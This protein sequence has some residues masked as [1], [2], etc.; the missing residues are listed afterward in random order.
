MDVK[1]LCLGLLNKGEACGYDLKKE[2]GSIFKHF[3]PAGY[4]SIY[5]AL[6]DLADKGLVSCE[7]IPQR[8]KPDRKT[9]RI[10]DEGR[11]HFSNALRNTTPRH[12]MRSEFLAMLYFSDLMD[13]DRLDDLLDERLKDLRAAII[14]IDEIERGWDT[15][16]AAGARFVAG[17]GASV[18][19]AAA[20]YI[21]LN[22]E[23]LI[24][25]SGKHNVGQSTDQAIVA[26]NRT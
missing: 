2:F 12:K 24:G 20:E 21:E 3:Y 10:T 18:A 19:K 5:P 17:F 26:G 16:A 7:E 9:Y 4:G 11:R 23:A 6:A 14:D 15:D 22:R 25:R 1:T 8:G 13:A